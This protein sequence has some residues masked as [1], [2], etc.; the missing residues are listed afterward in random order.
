M[1]SQTKVN[2]L[3]NGKNTIRTFSNDE[4]LVQVRRDEI[5]VEAC[6]VFIKNGY[7]GTSVR[8][9]AKALGK[10]TGMLYHYFGSKQDILY[11]ILELIVKDEQ[12]YL[13]DI[14]KKTNGMNPKEALKEALRLYVE[15]HEKYADAHV[16]VNHVLVTLKSGERRIITDSSRRVTTFFE[17]ILQRGIKEG[18]FHQ[19]DTRML[20]Q[21]IV[22]LGASWVTRRW[23]WKKSYTLDEFIRA[24][25][26]IILWAIKPAK[27]TDL[28]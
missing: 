15:A 12:D 27:H 23:Y 18:D 28:S 22:M 9:L 11:I 13:S 6:K 20:A 3:R 26:E 7:D 10:T 8:S 24:Q 14:Y 21:N 19:H 25:T 16:F 5:L 1:T 2:F 4:A 17:E